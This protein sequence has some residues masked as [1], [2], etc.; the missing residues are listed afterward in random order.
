MK[1]NRAVLLQSITAQNSAV[2]FLFYAVAMIVNLVM[3][4][5]EDYLRMTQYARPE[6]NQSALTVVCGL[7]SAIKREFLHFSFFSSSSSQG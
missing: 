6:L 5:T 1:F 7:I 2:A 3:M 4:Q